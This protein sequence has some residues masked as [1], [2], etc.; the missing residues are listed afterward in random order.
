MEVHQ[1]KSTAKS[2]WHVGALELHSQ[3]WKARGPKNG[4]GIVL[5]LD[6]FGVAHM[7]PKSSIEANFQHNQKEHAC[8]FPVP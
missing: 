7:A 4:I 8:T 1:Q 6:E 2:S 3:L 5:V